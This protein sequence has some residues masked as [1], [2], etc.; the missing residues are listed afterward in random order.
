M[1]H[2]I[3][4]EGPNRF[5]GVEYTPT[6][7]Y[8][9]EDCIWDPAYIHATYPEWYEKLFGRLTPEEAAAQEGHSCAMCTDDH[10]MYD[11]EDK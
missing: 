9:M 2:T 5:R 4:M 8:D 3:A 11:D 6:C 7:K 1:A 10:F